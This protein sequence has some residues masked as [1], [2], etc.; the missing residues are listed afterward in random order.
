MINEADS[1]ETKGS[2]FLLETLDTANIRTLKY[3]L[4]KINYYDFNNEFNYFKENKEEYEENLSFF[5]I[6]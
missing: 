3:L 2:K 1:P 4:I 5:E 6:F